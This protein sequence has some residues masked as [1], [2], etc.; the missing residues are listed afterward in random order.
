MYRGR[1]QGVKKQ[2]AGIVSEFYCRFT[3][4]L[5]NNMHN[6][7]SSV[8][9]KVSAKSLQN[10]RDNLSYDILINL[11]HSVY[12]Y[13]THSFTRYYIISSSILCV[14]LVLTYYNNIVTLFRKCHLSR[15][16]CGSRPLDR[17]NEN[18]QRIL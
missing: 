13:S 10:T 9:E 12:A 1:V 11:D 7:W 5:R 8:R 14:L 17:R 18:I 4:L 2:R 6:I 15:L 16:I 3:L